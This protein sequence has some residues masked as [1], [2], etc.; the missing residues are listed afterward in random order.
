MTHTLTPNTPGHVIGPGYRVPAVILEVAPASILVD[1]T[2]PGMAARV[3][4][5]STTPGARYLRRHGDTSESA[6]R[7]EVE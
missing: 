3:S 2:P 5:F 1:Y 7:F 4:W 6:L